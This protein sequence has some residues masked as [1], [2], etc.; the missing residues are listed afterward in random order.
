MHVAWFLFHFNRGEASGI[1]SHSASLTH[2]INADGENIKTLIVPASPVHY[3]LGYLAALPTIQ[4]LLRWWLSEH[5]LSEVSGFRLGI[6]ISWVGD[7]DSYAADF[8]N[9]GDWD[10]SDLRDGLNL[11]ALGQIAVDYDQLQKV[12]STAR[13]SL[14]TSV[15]DL[16]RLAFH[17]VEVLSSP[18]VVDIQGLEHLRKQWR[19]ATNVLARGS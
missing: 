8:E 13:L 4:G 5:H 10:L 18:S 2:C 14:L 3:V 12:C 19:L 15:L 6:K 7:F 9:E 16:F 11:V 17:N 1:P